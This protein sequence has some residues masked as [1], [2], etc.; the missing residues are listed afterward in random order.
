MPFDLQFHFGVFVLQIY[1]HKCNMMCSVLFT[2]ALTVMAKDWKQLRNPSSRGLVKL[3]FIK[4]M[5][6]EA[7]KTKK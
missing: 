2:A 6:C 3:L 4:K 5:N 7:I 1:F